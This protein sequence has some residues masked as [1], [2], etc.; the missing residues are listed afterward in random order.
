MR[1]QILYLAF[2]LFLSSCDYFIHYEGYA[3]DS[4]TS[5]AIQDV[6]VQL[7]ISRDTFNLGPSVNG[8]FKFKN[9]PIL[10]DS[11]GFFRVLRNIGSPHDHSLLFTNSEYQSCEI[12]SED[13]KN[14]TIIYIHFKEKLNYR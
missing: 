4:E 11:T 6:K 10:T 12:N 1:K 5:K 7:I 2:C 3:I 8:F 14:D 9:E 13:L